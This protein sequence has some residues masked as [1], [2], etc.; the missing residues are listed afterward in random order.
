MKICPNCKAQIDDNAAFCGF[1]GSRIVFPQQPAQ[2]RQPDPEPQP[3]PEQPQYQQADQ[4][5]QYQQ[6]TD[7]QY[8]QQ[9][10][11]QYQQQYQQNY[12][13]VYAGNPYDHTSD[14]EAEDISKNKIFAML[15]YLLDAVGI[16]IALLSGDSPYVRFHVRQSLK[17]TVIEML[18]AIC[19][20]VL[21][22]TIIVPVAGVIFLIILAVI[23]IICFFQVC[24]GKACEPAIIRSFKFLE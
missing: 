1:C 2:A 16:I 9:Q 24:G 20:A 12:A 15:V 5:Q 23:K 8:Q 6:Q 17:F 13:P 14:Y 10:Y 21:C 7:Q 18:S 4:Q 22:W 11:Q 19:I 3:Q